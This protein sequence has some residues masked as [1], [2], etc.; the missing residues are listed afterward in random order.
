MSICTFCA[1]SKAL[2]QLARPIWHSQCLYH[3]LITVSFLFSVLALECFG[4][5]KRSLPLMPLQNLKH[6]SILY[7]ETRPKP[8][9]TLY[10][11]SSSGSEMKASRKFIT[12]RPK[13]IPATANVG[14][15]HRLLKQNSDM[16]SAVKQCT[17]VDKLK[18]PLTYPLG[19]KE[20]TQ[21]ET[22]FTA[23]DVIYFPS[24]KPVLPA[25]VNNK[26]LSCGKKRIHNKSKKT[27]YTLAKID[28]KV[29]TRK[30]CLQSKPVRI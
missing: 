1:C 21:T 26:K 30:H 28:R 11:Q 9:R 3:L 5:A 23:K 24:D 4:K 20:N 17:I 13:S 22:H 27:E 10:R 2:F 8:S 6:F 18:S 12:E 15:S 7:C 25:I 14:S 16:F 19:R 29:P